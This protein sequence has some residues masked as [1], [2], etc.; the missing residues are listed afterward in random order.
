MR[1]RRRGTSKLPVAGGHGNP[2]LSARPRACDSVCVSLSLTKPTID[3]P[4]TRLYMVGLAPLLLAAAVACGSAP[5]ATLGST[6]AAARDNTD[7]FF[8][9]LALRF[10]PLTRSPRLALVRPRYVRGSLA[11]SRIYDDTAVWTSREGD[12]R[13]LVVSGTERADGRYA[14]DVVGDAPVPTRTADSRHIMQLRALGDGAYE[15]RSLDELAVGS[16]SPVALDE[17]RLRFL[18]AAE[19]HTAAQLRFGWR[20]ALPRTSAALGRL[21]TIDSLVTTPLGDSSTSVAMVVS[22]H[23]DRLREDFPDYATWV[24][25]YISRMRYRL[26][27]SD[28]DGSPFLQ[29]AANG[30]VVRIRARTRGGVLQ[31]LAGPVR[32]TPLDSMRLRLDFSSR[33]SVFTV[34]LT[35]L[36]ADVVPVREPSEIGWMVHFR[37]EPSWRFPLAVD[38]LM[39]DALRRPFG[40][41]GS[42]MRITARDEPGRPTILARDF[43]M[44]VQE[45]AIVRWIG[46]IGNSAMRDV[47]V[48][49]EKQKDQFFYDALAALGADLSAQLD[50]APASAR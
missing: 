22:L 13:T 19:G 15:W 11:P 17:M 1:P 14:L 16:A 8:R 12:V 46:G 26:T 36:V 41:E 28:Y 25:K 38:Y 37:R 2:P 6:P 20:A 21:F 33:V 10:G 18:A 39:R 50:G 32:E 9:A 5:A 29:V 7:D 44:D 40:G 48:R 31:P 23:A 24:G 3:V 30:D 47:T 35:N 45:S 43:H 34:G 49:V 4:R 42:W 27:L